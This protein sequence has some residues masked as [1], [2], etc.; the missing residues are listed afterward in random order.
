[1]TDTTKVK[2]AKVEF[3][4]SESG[5]F[6]RMYRNRKAEFKT[7]GEA[8]CVLMQMAHHAPTVGYDKTDFRIT[9]EDGYVYEGRYD[10]HHISQQQENPNRRIDLADHVRGHVTFLSGTRC[11]GHMTPENYR[12]VL[13]LYG[14]DTPEKQQAAIDW[15]ARYE[16]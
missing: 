1:V 9:W 12:E 7:V 14:F 11:P 6:Q 2:V 4:F 10:L 3:P 15:L 8:T 16:L 5:W 13:K